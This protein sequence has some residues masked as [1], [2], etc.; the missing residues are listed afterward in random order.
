M[1]NTLVQEKTMVELTDIV[2]ELKQVEEE[3]HN[4]LVSESITQELCTSL[5]K[6]GG[7]RLRPLLVLLSG[8]SCGAKTQDLIAIAVAAE[9]IHM[10]SLVHDDIIDNSHSRRGAE[11]INSSHGNKTAVLTGD[12]LF[13]NAFRLLAEAKQ[14]KSLSLMVKAIS[15]MC[16]GEI[17]QANSSFDLSQDESS[18]IDRIDKKTGKLITACCQAGALA[19]NASMAEIAALS[20]YGR[21]LGIA[22][23]IADDIL[24]YTGSDSSLGKPACNDLSQGI[25]TLPIL[26]LLEDEKYGPWL[27]DHLKNKCLALVSQQQLLK[28]LQETG[29]LKASETKAFQHIQQANRALDRIPANPHRDVLIS[30]AHMALK[31]KK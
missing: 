27:K 2:P 11:T 12:Y 8:K 31:R 28:A 20:E 23:Q 13:A 10:A 24:D 26:L 6:S 22:F 1:T 25:L 3:L 21:N 5:L 30:I 19:A 7:K 15:D 14:Y 4:V 17:C 9:L 16:D 29:A 18:Y